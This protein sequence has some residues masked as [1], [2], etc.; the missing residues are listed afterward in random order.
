MPPTPPRLIRRARIYGFGLAGHFSSSATHQRQPRIR[1][2]LRASRAPGS[3]GL[4]GLFLSSWTIASELAGIRDSAVKADVA[5]DTFRENRV[6]ILRDST[7]ASRKP[8]DFF[9]IALS[10]K[11]R[12]TSIIIF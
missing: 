12:M 1:F 11:L 3:R 8:R 6:A 10:L 9:A 7:E 4:S 2:R 5:R